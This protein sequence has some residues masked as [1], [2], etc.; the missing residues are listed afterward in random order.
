[1]EKE[2]LIK[3]LERYEAVIEYDDWFISSI[4]ESVIEIT[5]NETWDK[6]LNLVSSKILQR[7]NT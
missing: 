3:Q 4:K 5:D 1:M 2:E 6:V 7:N